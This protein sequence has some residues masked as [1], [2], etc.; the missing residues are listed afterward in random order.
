[1][2]ENHWILCVCVEFK[3]FV[4]KIIKMYWN[5]TF[6]F[7]I[8][9]FFIFYFRFQSIQFSFSAKWFENWINL[10]RVVGENLKFFLFWF[11]CVSFVALLEFI[12]KWKKSKF[13]SNFFWMIDFNNFLF[14]SFFFYFHTQNYFSKEK[15]IIFFASFILLWH[16]KDFSFLH[17]FLCSVIKAFWIFFFC[18]P[19]YNP[20]WK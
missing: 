6:I 19:R 13:L 12:E 9:I 5:L 2:F 1:M 10:Q 7:F 18:L 16:T 11:Y 14:N 17:I 8:I 3:N 4:S 15:V 20:L